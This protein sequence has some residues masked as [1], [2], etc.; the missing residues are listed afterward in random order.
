MT[1]T[2]EHDLTAYLRVEADRVQVRDTLVDIERGITV[3]PFTA[4]PEH[5][6]RRL[7]LIGAVASI[8][9]VTGMVI[10][11]HDAPR[12]QQTAGLA[13]SPTASVNAPD[14]SPATTQPSTVPPTTTPPTTTLVLVPL[15]AGARI[16]GLSPSCTTTDSL[17]YECTI[18]E[19]PADG[20]APDMTGYTTIIVDD[21]SHVSGGCRST[22]TDATTFTCYVGQRSIDEGI[23]GA[24]S[25]GDWAPQG[26]IAG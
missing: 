16:Q 25:L 24:D 10:A 22:S 18:A 23:V 11:R 13:E 7:P 2:M 26:Y 3:V 8:A 17:V 4:R 15:P 12:E 20:R 1:P 6:R 5:P 14:A 19:F 21:T 9:I